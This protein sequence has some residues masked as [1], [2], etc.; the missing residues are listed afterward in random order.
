MCFDLSYHILILTRQDVKQSNS[1]LICDV[2]LKTKM[3]EQMINEHIFEIQLRTKLFDEVIA[4][5]Q[6]VLSFMI[7]VTRNKDVNITE[8]RKTYDVLNAISSISTVIRNTRLVLTYSLLNDFV[9]KLES[10][11][12]F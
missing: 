9:L 12:F 7:N 8:F 4:S 6:P 11:L 5:S 3:V 10:I 1:K 2:P